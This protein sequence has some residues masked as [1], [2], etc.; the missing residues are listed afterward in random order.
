MPPC[1][2]TAAKAGYDRKVFATKNAD[3]TWTSRAYT[4]CLPYDLDLTEAHQSGRIRVCKLWLVKDDKEFVFSNTDPEMK[5]GQAY[6]IV[7]NEG[8]LSFEASGASVVAEAGEGEDVLMWGTDNPSLGLWRGSFKRIGNADASAMLAYS[9]QDDRDFRRI[10]VEAPQA[11]WEAFRA[12]FCARAFTGNNTYGSKFK[13][14]VQ[15]G[16]DDDPLIDFP[17]DE[18]VGDTD[19]PDSSLGMMH[20]IND[21]G[22]HAYFDLQ[23]RQLPGSPSK[24]GV[25]IN[26]GKVVMNR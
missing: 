4:V 24:K 5:A 23:G 10:S 15:G 6:L 17:A 22:S 18:F 21:D 9:M 2:F 7:V 13:Q 1:E 16:D 20:V 19:I 26:N 25:Y 3:G 14:Y 11:S 12:M 8:E